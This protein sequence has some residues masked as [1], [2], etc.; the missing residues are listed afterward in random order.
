MEGLT[1]R[2]VASSNPSVSSFSTAPSDEASLH[3]ILIFAPNS[4]PETRFL[5][6]ARSFYPR[7]FTMLATPLAFLALAAS[8]FASHV[9]PTVFA[10]DLAL[11]HS[12]GREAYINVDLVAGI[13]AADNVRSSD[14]EHAAVDVR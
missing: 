13:L 14:L 10:R 7:S 2:G 4:F 6:P 9:A 1:R 12:G 11:L 8:A 3:L 5:S